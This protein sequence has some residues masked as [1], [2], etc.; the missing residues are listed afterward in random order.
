MKKII[1]IILLSLVFGTVLAGKSETVMVSSSGITLPIIMYHSIIPEDDGRSDYIIS[2]KKFEEDIAYLKIKGYSPINCMDLIKYT[3]GDGNL[4]ENPVIITF[5]DGMYNNFV[6]G[7]P[8]LQKYGYKAVFSL[9]G[10][11][12]DEYTENGILNPEYSYIPWNEVS[13]LS[14]SPYIEFANH[15]YNLHTVKQ[16]YGPQKKSGESFREYLELFSGD[17]QK[18]QE[19]FF[20]NCAYSPVI[21]TYPFG[22]F[23]AESERILKKNGYLVTLSCIEG[24]NKI[25]KNP[26]CLYLLKRYNRSGK[27]ST[28]EFFNKIGL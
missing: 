8:I 21:Y 19:L 2:E 22:G 11:Y 26:D 5:D 24:M 17:T 6:Y 14:T 12:T 13:R 25:T 23:C 28:Q 4:P 3:N 20:K 10:S 1:G 7:V 15:S 9:V 27:L 18:M 16:R